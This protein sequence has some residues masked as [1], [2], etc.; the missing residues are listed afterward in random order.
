MLAG[1]AVAL[2]LGLPHGARASDYAVGADLSFL[3]PDDVLLAAIKPP[4]QTNRI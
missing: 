3:N 4:Q 2:C 1:L